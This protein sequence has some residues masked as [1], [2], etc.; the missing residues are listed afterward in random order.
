MGL[1]RAFKELLAASNDATKSR[2]EAAPMWRRVDSVRPIMDRESAEAMVNLLAATTDPDGVGCSL[3]A[4]SGKRG[5]MAP[6]RSATRV[7][8]L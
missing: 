8:L 2:R 3:T 4:F 5:L 7:Q 1:E 6:H